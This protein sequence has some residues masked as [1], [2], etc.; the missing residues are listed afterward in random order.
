[1]KAKASPAEIANLEAE[2]RHHLLLYHDL[3]TPVISDQAFDKL[4]EKLQGLAP[5][6]PVLSER[7]QYDGD[8][9]H[10]VPM[11]SLAKVKTVEDLYR[12]FAGKTVTITPK[13]D[14]AGL[15][16]RYH[17]RRLLVSATRGKSE[18]QKGK[19][20]TAIISAIPSIPKVV[21]FDGDFEV[22]GEAVI[23]KKD[24][25]LLKASNPELSNA[26]NAASGGI[27]SRN[28]ED[29][30]GR[31]LT[32]IAYKV[33]FG[34]VDGKALHATTLDFLSRSG[35]TTPDYEVTTIRSVKEAQEI[36]DRWAEIRKGL[37]Y[38]TD[39]I[40]IRVNNEKEFSDAGLT[41]N[42]WNGGAAF[43]YENEGAETTIVDISWEPSRIGFITP[44]AH[45]DTIE[46]GGSKFEKC[47]LNNPTWM[48]ENG[49]PTIGSRVIVERMND[50]IPN[51]VS[52]LTSGTGNTKQ[53]KNCPCCGSTLAFAETNDG[54]GAKLKCSNEDCGAK[55]IKHVRRV[56]EV[57]EVKGMDETTIEKMGNAGLLPK[58]WSVFDL[59]QESLVKAGFGKKESQNIV[60]SVSGLSAKPESLIAACGIEGW[61]RRM[62]CHLI[63]N[64]NETFTEDRLLAGDFPYEELVEVKGVGPAKAKLL[65][66]AFA[67]SARGSVFLSELLKRVKPVK[68]EA[69]PAGAPGGKL[70]GKSYLIT[71]TLS[72]PRKHFEGLVVTNGGRLASGVSKNLDGLIVGTDSGG[73]LAKAQALGIRILSEEEFLD[74]VK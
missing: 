60:A 32:Y 68:A 19:N 55:A 2:I 38:E 21:D 33:V 45:F 34:D 11:G 53:P 31:R 4:I 74:M 3:H 40:V 20:V 63:E 52:V 18:T 15:M 23:L 73:K 16:N 41:S 49:N 69:K 37:P 65:S 7:S 8:F 62:V 28:I 36:V 26:R 64:S 35:F 56:L 57:L 9:K 12:K 47:T 67:P 30:R 17:D 50:V 29:V 5:Q 13:V 71:G 42:C 48:A 70:A 59:T 66:E 51:I 39:G 14:G 1:M 72:Q 43:K 22:R 61:G 10:D 46:L 24:W 6:S 54:E 27:N 58:V 44:V 25:E